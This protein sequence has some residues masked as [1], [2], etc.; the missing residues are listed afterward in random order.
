LAS[1]VDT[2]PNVAATADLPNRTINLTLT[3]P[4]LNITYQFSVAVADAFRL[5][6]EGA[7]V[8]PATLTV[9][10]SPSAAQLAT[11]FLGAQRY[12]YEVQSGDTPGS[13]AGALAASL[14]SDPDVSATASG[15]AISLELSGNPDTLRLDLGGATAVPAT[16]TV[17]GTPRAG[18]IASAFLNDLRLD[19]IVRQ[20]DSLDDIAAGLA[21]PLNANVNVDA[22]ANG[23]AIS[24]TLQ[25][26]T[27]SV[28]LDA[29][30]D[31]PLSATATAPQV[32]QV[33]P[34]VQHFLP[35]QG[36]A[37]NTVSA[38]LG[39][40]L[41]AVP[42]DVLFFNDP[43]PG[44]TVTVTLSDTVYSYTVVQ[45]DTLTDLLT[46]LAA[47]ISGD[48]NV[49]ATADTGASRIVLTLTNPT[50]EASIGF[51]VSISPRFGDLLAF[52]RSATT[53]DSR[54]APVLF[55]GPVKGTAGLYQ[56]NFSVPSD[57]PVDPAS[58]LTFSQ[59][60]IV[61]GSVTNF[62]I[63]SN[64]VTFPVV[65]PMQVD[66]GGATAVPATLTFSGNPVAGQSVRVQLADL[67]YT[68]RTVSGDTLES[69][70]ANLAAILDP[71]N[72]VSATASG[73]TV[74]LEL[75]NAGATVSLTVTLGFN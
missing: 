65:A 19:Y 41:P 52:A 62:D 48:P 13:I 63:F 45:G 46:K 70:A 56:V 1:A 72:D 29:E 4:N 12:E 9:R 39:E 69:I 75:T 20:G 38:F 10:G 55:A 7:G 61:F 22:V 11:V 36:S 23:P 57:A 28:S 2:D 33:L 60:L 26:E 16:L 50:S 64:Q 21:V 34:S 15:A 74:R 54:P 51:T 17:R 37:S 27:A 73:S 66:T 3:T 53:T 30:V 59:N 71:N 40:S 58:K 35:G 14:N 47:E 43:V 49:T 44:E 8:V 5:D 42:G 31:L 25:N 24:L 67:S 18:M 68:Y 32:L 6:T